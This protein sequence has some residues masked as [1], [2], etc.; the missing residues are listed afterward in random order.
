MTQTRTQLAYVGIALLLVASVAPPPIQTASAAENS[1]VVEQGDRCIEVSPL[2]GDETA[3]EFYDYRNPENSDEYTYSSYMPDHLTEDDESR[4]FL[5]EGSDGVS[6]VMVHNERGGSGDGHAVTF[7][8][9]GLPS[10]GEWA[11][12]DDDYSD[13]D[14]EYSRDR[15]DWTLRNDRTDGGA[16]RGLDSEGTEITVTPSFN[17]DAALYE[18]F[19]RTGTM[20]AWRFLSGDLGNPDAERLDMSR[21]VTIR[22]GHCTDET[23]PSA[24]LAAD[25]G[26]AGHEVTLD[27]SGSSDNRGIEEYRWDFDGDGEV[28][29]T[30]DTA[31]VGHVYEESGEYRPEVT[32]VDGG[33]NAD[34]AATNVTVEPDDPPSAALDVAT[35]SPTEGFRVSLDAGGSSDDVGVE[36]YRWDFDGDGETDETTD[37]P[38]V[39]HVYNETGTYD[40]SVTVV[41]GS[42]QND[43]ATASVTVEP[44]DPP[45][46]ALDV[47]TESP[48][49]GF[50][51]DLDAGGSSDDVGIEEYRWDFDGDGEVDRTTSDPSAGHVYNETGTYDASVTVV[52]GSDQNDTATASVEVGADEP[53]EP[54]IEVTAPDDPVEGEQVSFDASDSTDDTGI[55]EYRWDFGDDET[56]TGETVTHTYDG[57]G[58]FEVTLEVVDEGNNSATETADVE[59][60]APDDTP[61]EADA[62]AD[63]DEVEADANVTFDAGGSTDN[64]EISSY[65]WEFDDGE[66]AEGERVTHAY[67]ESGTYDATVTVT[68]GNDNTDTANVTVEVFEARPPNVSA[69]VPETLRFGEEME[70]EGS[71]DDNGAVAGYEWEFGDGTTAE[72]EAATHTYEEA[73]NYT[74][75]LTATDRGGHAN[76]TTE[77]VTVEEPDTTPPTAGLSVDENETTVDDEV[78][79]DASDS[80]DNETGIES[81]RWD[82]DGDGETDE[83]T[84][85][86]S[87]DHAYEEVDTFDAS[88][89]VVDGGDNTDTA[90]VNVTVEAE[91]KAHRGDDGNSGS[92][93]GSSSGDGGGGG[94]GPPAVLT[95]TEERGANAALVDV[96]NAR[97]DEPVA[98]S[99]PETDAAAETGVEF[100]SV[101]VDLA[102]DDPHFAV[103]TARDD[104]N[105]TDIPSDVAL[106]S[107]AVD[108]RY[109]DADDVSS[110]TYEAAVERSRLDDAGLAAADLTAFERTDGEW[111]QVDAEIE[112][113]DGTVLVRAN[114]SALA[115][116][117]VGADHTTTL[118]D[119]A[120]AEEEVGATDPVEVTATVENE[121]EEA[122]E[123]TTELTVDGEVVDEKTV[124]VP[125]G[126]TAEVEFERQ[127]DPGT[128]EVGVGG[129]RVGS[130][131]VADPEPDIGVA[132]LSLSDSTIEEGQ[133]V[134]ITATV[135]NSGTAAGEREVGLTLFGERLDTE[136]VE[137][138][139]GETTEVTFVQRID[140]PGS[141]EPA[142]GD[143]SAE[144]EVEGGSDGNG[145]SDSDGDG[146]IDTPGVPGFGVGAAVAALLAATLLARLRGSKST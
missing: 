132:D 37:G 24:A 32:V 6:L 74:V 98:L 19:D 8:F 57:N 142:V 4:L 137:L 52:D 64:R 138:D 50:R 9:G 58:T 92:D 23:P 3:E 55:E 117:A 136:T 96:R 26:V 123:F 29:Q 47:A 115:D 120:L 111:R 99:L 82:F 139:A 84:E 140:A 119:A 72:G 7:E 69:S 103:E 125:G 27:A 28:E 45:S 121:A 17:E 51:V 133:Q 95:D 40:A 35:E 129:E 93:S 44:D 14:D 30:T 11:V 75:T 101:R 127:L 81:Y 105:A 128:H 90:T 56:A 36:E 20:D 110:V 31:T 49:E 59:V 104:E 67:D 61:P 80:A 70:V 66:T 76:R 43:T 144:L 112:E 134:E 88:V 73:G 42:D 116:V 53:P 108:S 63:R 100:D 71:A 68:D 89:T 54:E 41:D 33:D 13:P 97:S 34:T 141:Y 83:T 113:R 126:E 5:Y 91:E 12:V 38:E 143:R 46:A 146:D 107:L 2:Q 118:T 18:E 135:E 145:E 1:F 131:T 122:R 85:D 48:T 77:T 109:I 22:T 114:A 102:D 124:E 39:G 87:V 78:T 62:S 130:V 79:F 25:G 10:G 65:E 106:G 21:P 15:I 86:A 60:L 16:F 94:G